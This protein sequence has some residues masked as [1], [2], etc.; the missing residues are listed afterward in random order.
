[1]KAN[2]TYTPTGGSPNTEDKKHQDYWI[3]PLPPPGAVTFVCEW[4]KLEIPETQAT[5][6]GEALR[7]A[8]G[9]AERVW[10]AHSD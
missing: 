7:E 3:W 4:P 8:A 1:V 9:R 2:V 6:E 5:I 10:P